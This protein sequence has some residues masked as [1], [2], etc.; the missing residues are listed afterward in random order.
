MGMMGAMDDLFRTLGEFYAFIAPLGILL[1]AIT[2]PSILLRRRGRPT[3][4]LAWLM[5]VAFAPILGA[6]AW[7]MIGRTHLQRHR[8]ARETEVKRVVSRHGPIP[9]DDSSLF[10]GRIPRAALGDSVFPSVGNRVEL[11]VDGDAAYPAMEAAIE[12]AESSLMVLFYIWKPDE[13]GRRLR[14]LLAERARAGVKVRVLVDAHGSPRFDGRFAAP[15]EDAGAEVAR[16]MPWRLLRWTPRVNFVNHR[17]IIVVD[18][19]VAFTGGMNVGDEYR[20][21]WRDL[22]MRIEGKAVQALRHVFLSDWAAATGSPADAAILDPLPPP[23]EDAGALVDMAVVASG[24]DTEQPWIHLGYFQAFTRATA[25]IWI[26]TP[27]FIPSNA[28]SVALQAAAVRGV[29]VRLVVPLD[30][31]VPLVAWACRSYYPELLAAGVHIYEYKGPMLHA[32]AFVVDDVLCSVG[33][34]NVDTRSFH[35]SFEV[36]CFM[37]S[38]DLTRQLADWH[39]AL[40]ADSDEIFLSQIEGQSTVRTLLESAAHLASPLL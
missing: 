15:L 18:D 7:W 17:K 37:L 22:M 25:R 3:A 12:G 19:R 34:A 8:E 39:A 32:K 40:V 2:A 24:P 28:L 23:A 35:L 27:Y 11:L 4:A 5:L 33:T 21:V 9:M 13:T 36:G 16:V 6:I 14:D 20:H 30:N 31:D 29:D 26:A 10:Q 38:P 1:A